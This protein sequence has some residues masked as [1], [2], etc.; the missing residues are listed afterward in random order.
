MA[1]IYT[2]VLDLIGHTPL[3]EPVKFGA[4][5][6][7]QARLLVK[8]ESFDQQ[9]F[10]LRPDGS[11]KA[12]DGRE[13]IWQADPAIWAQH[14]PVL[15]PVCCGVR[16]DH[17]RIAGQEYPMTKHGFAQEA[18]FQ[19][20]HVGD[21]FVDLVL[22]P[23]AESRAMYPFN[24]AFHV[25]YRLFEGGYTT[26]FLVENRSDRVMP[27]CVGGH[28]AFTCPMEE[29]AAFEDYQLVFPELEEGRNTLVAEADEFEL[30]RIVLF[31]ERV[32]H[33]HQAVPVAGNVRDF[34][35]IDRLEIHVGRV[36]FRRVALVENQ[37]LVP[38]LD[39]EI[40]EPRAVAE[41]DKPGVRI[42]DA[43]RKLTNPGFWNLKKSI[44]G[45]KAIPQP[46]SVLHDQGKHVLVVRG[47]L[48]TYDDEL[49]V[50]SH[51]LRHVFAKERGAACEGTGESRRRALAHKVAV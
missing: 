24:F 23:T 1:K 13:V 51:E 39:V 25:T 36:G 32:R 3:L 17:I 50:K 26:T 12:A 41:L 46:Q 10:T 20:A 35:D 8:L 31:E 43:I 4:D 15:F 33:A 28:P 44:A 29:G 37:I 49:L 48:R 27:L 2:S 22:T 6:N 47:V 34:P 42:V 21:D 38:F 16:N 7:L 9:I 45:C 30:V 40:R 14:A 11:F 5:K 18:E 19:V